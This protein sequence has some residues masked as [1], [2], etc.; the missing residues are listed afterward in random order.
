MTAF[1]DDMESLRRI[2]SLA[3]QERKLPAFAQYAREGV[4]WHTVKGMPKPDV[5]DALRTVALAAGLNDVDVQE[6]L[7]AAID[8]PYVPPSSATTGGPNGA[9]EVGGASR[10]Q[11]AQL[12]VRR[13]SEIDPQPV[14]WLWPNRIPLG[15]V[16]L[17][18]GEPGLGKSQLTC[19]I[20]AAVTSGS[21][22]PFDEGRAPSGSVIILSAEDDAADT[23]RPRLEAASAD[24]SRVFVVSAVQRDDQGGRRSF[25]LQADLNLLE[26]EI[27][28]AGDVALVVIDPVSSYL[29][30]VDSHNNANLRAVLEPMGEMA[31]RLGVGILAVTHLNK[32]GIGSAN[33]RIIGSIAFVAAARAAYVVVRDQTDKDRRLF[34]PTKNNVGPEGTGLSFRTQLL[35][36]TG[37]IYAP[38]IVWEEPVIISADE[39]LT[40][41]TSKPDA[42]PT[43]AA[44]EEF[45][46]EILGDAPLPVRRIETEA[47]AAGL[48]WATVRRAR[49]ALGI[50]TAKTGLDGGWVWQ[51]PGG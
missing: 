37:D 38:A 40:A 31:A 44:A 14:R 28:R 2:L 34:L 22:W 36:I 13:V 3:A 29:G 35:K 8:H 19:A 32:A 5:I 39:A 23:M 48:S 41:N 27:K 10:R 6:S 47:K 17:L 51:L 15:K 30:K 49:D 12:V 43:R 20:A 1:S 46:L 25:N 21:S 9:A 26:M 50:K 7:Q 42:A 4:R 45:L 11:R 33:N 18:A 16:T 24:L